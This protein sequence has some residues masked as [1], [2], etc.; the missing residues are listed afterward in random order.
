MTPQAILELR[1]D[2]SVI[3]EQPWRFVYG[4][5]GS[6]GFPVLLLARKRIP[7]AAVAELLRWGRSR[8]LV[9]GTITR[10][11]DGHLVL[12]ADR[13]DRAWFIGLRD[14]FG[15]L[16]PELAEARLMLS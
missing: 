7:T 1:R 9:R 10:D 14:F 2:L 16:I 8:V 13:G 4:P 11:P 12:R 3:G 5:A 15:P 6:D